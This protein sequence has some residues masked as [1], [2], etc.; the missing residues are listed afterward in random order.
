MPTGDVE[1]YYAR[2]EWHNRIEGTDLVFGTDPT[3]GAAVW[4]G[5]ARARADATTHVVRGL[6][7]KVGQRHSYSAAGDRDAARRLTEARSIILAG[8]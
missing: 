4:A 5:R 2:N 8:S 7:G 3:R 6:D 1:T